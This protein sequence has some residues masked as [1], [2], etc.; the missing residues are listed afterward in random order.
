[1][2]ICCVEMMKMFDSERNL[3]DALVMSLYLL[4][5]GPVCVT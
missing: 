3:G 5:Q 4:V 2:E 1:M